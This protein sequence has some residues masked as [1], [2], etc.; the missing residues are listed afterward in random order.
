[1]TDK[2]DREMQDKLAEILK[3]GVTDDAMKALHKKLEDIT[4]YIEDDLMY[5]LKDDLAPN[6]AAYVADMAQR[7]VEMLLEGNED[8]MRRYL[9]CEKR[10]EDGSYIGWN[11]RSDGQRYGAKR[12]DADQHP[13]IHGELFETGCIALRQRIVEAHRDLLVNERVLDLEDQVKSLVAQVNKATAE[14]EKM[15]ERLRQ[16][17]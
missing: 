16:C 15:W 9:S 6:L 11:G 14:K 8:Q 3:A 4:C 12:A 5:R 1:M 10:G 2:I 13:V 7:A 17:A